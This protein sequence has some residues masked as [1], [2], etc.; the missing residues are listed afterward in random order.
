VLGDG[1][2]VGD[3]GVRRR[4]GDDGDGIEGSPVRPRT[5]RGGTDLLGQSLNVG[6]FDPDGLV[7]ES[8]EVQ[9][10]PLDDV[11]RILTN[12]NRRYS[13]NLPGIT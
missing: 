12:V 9:R 4:V 1:D 10:V 6:V 3:A 5:S 11:M 13:P 2:G 8:L 7:G